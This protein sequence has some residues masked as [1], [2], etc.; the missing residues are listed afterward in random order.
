MNV[1]SVKS[2]VGIDRRKKLQSTPSSAFD[3]R[4][5][6][7]THGGS[8]EMRARTKT[9]CVLNSE[10]EGLWCG[11]LDKREIILAAAGGMLY[12]I[13]PN[14]YSASALGSIG[15]GECLMFE[16]ANCVY[17]KTEGY[18]GKYDGNTLAEVEG[19][20]PCVAI[21]CAPSGEGELFE[22]INL[23]SDKRRQLFSGDGD[24]LYYRLAEADISE[25]I[26]IK[27]DGVEYVGNYS[28]DSTIGAVSFEKYPNAGLNNIEITYR[29]AYG[30]SDKSRIMK[31]KRA[32]LFGGNSDGRVFLWGN[33]DMPNCRF[34]S[35]LANGVPSAEYFPVNGFTLIGSSKIN[36]IIQQYD[37]MLI[38]TKNEAFYSYCELKAD[39]LGNV[40]SSF[41]VFSLNGGKGCLFE[42]NGCVI[43]NRPVTLCDDG[44]NMWESTSVENEKNA[45]CFSDPINEAIR[46]SVSFGDE[47]FLFDLQALGELYFIANGTAFVYN[48]RLGAWYC[49]D[50]FG[51]SHFR[52][53]RDKLYYASGSG[54]CAYSEAFERESG[55]YWQSNYISNGHDDNECDVTLIQADIYVR[56]GASVTF[57]AEK[58][59]GERKTRKFSFGADT[60]RYMRIAFRPSLKRALP[61]RLSVYMEGGLCVLHSLTAK[62]RKKERSRRFGI[63]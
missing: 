62:T 55:G 2:F 35:E 34:H 59:N 20:I 58:S 30:E 44:L 4:N 37:K 60:D 61:F 40:V 29:K 28:L 6:R 26:S 5:L 33:E 36:C 19:Y 54:L 17:C 7:V 51:G 15:L 12:L 48:Y 46:E 21:S 41:P 38:F 10:I 56:G 39:A 18:Y 22:E 45:I 43:D 16:F 52:V 27:V 23:L 42:T 32:M 49:Y 11:S 14:T 9:L 63:L 3:M 53:W 31:C 25:I 50:S 13:D 8:L 57:T 1:T 47:L 24:S